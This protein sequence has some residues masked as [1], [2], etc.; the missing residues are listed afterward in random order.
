M[1]VPQKTLQDTTST[2]K[3]AG[4]VG[5]RLSSSLLWEAQDYGRLTRVKSK[6]LTSKQPEQRGLE[7]WIKQ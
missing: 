2:E 3:K 5:V 4:R 7:A 1:P 6:T